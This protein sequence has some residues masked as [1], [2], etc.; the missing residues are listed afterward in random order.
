MKHVK[1]KDVG[2]IKVRYKKATPMTPRQLEIDTWEDRALKAMCEA[3]VE[4]NTIRARDGTPRGS[5]VT[6]EYWDD[7]MNRLDR[8]ILERTGNDAHCNAILYR[9]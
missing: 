6:Q 8:L 3:W 2:K 9:A 1:F 4:M 7:I 5:S